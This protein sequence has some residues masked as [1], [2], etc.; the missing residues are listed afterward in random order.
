MHSLI[1]HLMAWLH[2]KEF[3]FHPDLIVLSVKQEKKQDGQDC[4]EAY[5]T[6]SLSKQ[7]FGREEK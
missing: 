7:D 5:I 4:M 6:G 2:P 3:H 1:V